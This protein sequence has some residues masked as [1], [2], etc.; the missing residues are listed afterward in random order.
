MV[1]PTTQ[2]TTL[3]IQQHYSG[4][5]QKHSDVDYEL[6]S[7]QLGVKKTRRQHKPPAQ[8]YKGIRNIS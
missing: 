2:M 5:L 6:M 4:V 7:K 8:K 3:S 1:Q